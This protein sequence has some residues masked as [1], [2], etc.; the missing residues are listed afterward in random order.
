MEAKVEMLEFRNKE[1][2]RTILNLQDRI[3]LFDT[4]H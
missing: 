3:D 1:L 2:E 4:C